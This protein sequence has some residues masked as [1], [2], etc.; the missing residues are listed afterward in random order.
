MIFK[1]KGLTAENF[2]ME[3]NHIIDGFI[4]QGSIT[5]IY[6]P[7]K[8]SKSGLA[9]GVLKHIIENTSFYC[10]YLD[11]D[12]GIA[13]LTDKRIDNFIEKYQGKFDYLNEDI[14]CI[15]GSSALNEMVEDCR[16]NPEAYKN[17]VIFFDSVTDFCDETSDTSAK[18][19][20]YK[21]KKLRNAGAT[22]ILLHHTN[23]RNGE[24]KGSSVFRS[25]SDNVFALTSEVLCEDEDNILLERQNARFGNIANNAF[26]LKK[27]TWDITKVNYDDFCMPYHRREA[28]NQIIRV[29][30][31][32]VQL[33][34]TKLLNALG[35]PDDKTY[36]EILA[37]YSGRYWLC[38]DEGRGKSK[39]YTLR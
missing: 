17:L 20:M 24:Y 16:N 10:C 23:K 3:V 12:N 14:L 38:R 21:V 30:K 6:A 13:A 35:K 15:S 32:E 2:N 1:G 4:V 26:H 34:Q 28:I 22:V 5:L 9:M 8:N 7:P 18:A 11:F 36:K 29:L 31:K 39:L 25:A 33:N 19:F 27:Y 37:E